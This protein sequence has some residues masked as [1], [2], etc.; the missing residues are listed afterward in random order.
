MV[1]WAM[2]RTRRLS[3]AKDVRAIIPDYK[4]PFI[5]VLIKKTIQ[6]NFDDRTC[7]VLGFT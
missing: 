5:K 6:L 2:R 4:R 1:L 7:L 3:H